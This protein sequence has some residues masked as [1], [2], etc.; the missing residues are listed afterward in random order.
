MWIYLIDVYV[1]KILFQEMM[2]S[3]APYERKLK[4]LSCASNTQ[5]WFTNWIFLY[6][7]FY[8]SFRNMNFSKFSK[9]I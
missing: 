2:V 5:F 9:L 7:V 8:M 4:Y 1:E 6:T 3:P